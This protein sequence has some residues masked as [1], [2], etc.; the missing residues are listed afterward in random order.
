MTPVRNERAIEVIDIPTTETS[1]LREERDATHVDDSET[2]PEP[3]THPVN[4]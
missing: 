3:T 1:K 4:A 2:E